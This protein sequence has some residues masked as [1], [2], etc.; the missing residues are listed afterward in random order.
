M[1]FGL[2]ASDVTSPNH[3]SWYAAH[4]R[5]RKP[6]SSI[7][8]AGAGMGLS[9]SEDDAYSVSDFIDSRDALKELDE[10]LGYANPIRADVSTSSI[11]LPGLY[12]DDSFESFYLYY[13]KHVEVEYDPVSSITILTC[14]ASARRMP[15]ASTV[16]CSR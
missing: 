15:T 1:Y 5:E 3:A 16:C 14:A 4:S 13:G 9:R 6:A 2:I 8:S 7:S 11:D 12:W 10:K